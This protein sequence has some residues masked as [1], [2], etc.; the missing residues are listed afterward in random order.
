MT[1]K[2]LPL[3][4]LGNCIRCRA[5]LLPLQED[6]EEAFRRRFELL[7]MVD[8]SA[9]L[10]AP[11]DNQR[12]SVRAYCRW[13]ESVALRC[14]PADQNVIELYQQHRLH[15]DQVDTSTLELDLNALSAW[16]ISAALALRRPSLQNPVKLAA[17]RYASKVFGKKMKKTARPMMKWMM[18][19]LVQMIKTCKNDAIGW[20]DRVCL[21]ALSLAMLRK[22]AAAAIRLV[23]TDPND[24]LSF[25]IE[26]SD[27][28]IMT[29]PTLGKYIRLSIHTDKNAVPGRPRYAYIPAYTRIGLNFVADLTY[30]L[31]AFPV[32][33]GFLF[34]APY[35]KHGKSFRSTPYTQWDAV[36]HRAYNRAFPNG[37]KVVASHSCRKSVIQ[38]IFNS[39]LSEAKLGDIVGWLSV[40]S[41]VLRYYASLSIDNALTIVAGICDI[42]IL[43]DTT[44]T[45]APP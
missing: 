15:F 38:A 18:A 10:T 20:H 7:S 26:K 35:N 14:L 37:K 34:A 25:D 22:G 39:G 17:V 19:E 5:L 3:S 27:V 9:A 24:P 28:I 4:L 32:P 40:K 30:Y 2:Q 41:T 36:V 6:N 23:R 44:T 42:V 31:T 29:H 21:E 8:A 1:E 13:G 33:D 16:H 12:N 11:T 45:V 43:G